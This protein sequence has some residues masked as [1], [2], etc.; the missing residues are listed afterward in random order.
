MSRATAELCE[1]AGVTSAPPA[2]ACTT[3]VAVD[4]TKSSVHAIR[5]EPWSRT[6]LEHVSFMVSLP[7]RGSPREF[8]ARTTRRR[9]PR[10]YF[11]A[12]MPQERSHTARPIEPSSDERSRPHDAYDDD[13]A[14][15]RPVRA[16]GARA[17][18]C[19]LDSDAAWN[20]RALVHT[21]RAMRHRRSD[22]GG[23]RFARDRARA[24]LGDRSPG[25]DPLRRESGA[26]SA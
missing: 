13:G 11:A 24:R 10:C 23:A 19:S 21:V 12:R 1:C 2:V 15:A 22:D 18:R 5:A 25:G 16:D 20:D 6:S 3:A 7:F 8:R 26:T 17:P 14:F 4:A 9:R